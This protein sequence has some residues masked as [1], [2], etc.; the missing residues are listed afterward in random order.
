[1]QVQIL[2]RR[3]N[4]KVEVILQHLIAV[5]DAHLLEGILNKNLETKDIQQT[6]ASV[7]IFTILVDPTLE[8]DLCNNGQKH[9]V[10]ELSGEGVSGLSSLLR[11][12]HNRDHAL[13]TLDTAVGEG[14]SQDLRVHAQ[15]LAD[16]FD[17]S[18]VR[19]FTSLA[20]VDRVE[21]HISQ[22]EDGAHNLS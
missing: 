18:R 13:T 3:E 17:D 14:V 11:V 19:D 5:V 22:Q 7:K 8:I 10:I 12:E 6:N 20:V 15:K 16:S 2:L 1:M 21:A 4:H 9:L